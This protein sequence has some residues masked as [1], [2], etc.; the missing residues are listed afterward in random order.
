MH[1]KKGQ[2]TATTAAQA[3]KK[4]NQ[5]NNQPVQATQ[6]HLK[7]LEKDEVTVHPAWQTWCHCSSSSKQ[8]H[9]HKRKCNGIPKQSVKMHWIKDQLTAAA[10]A[11]ANK[12]KKTKTTINLCGLAA[13]P[14]NVKASKGTGKKTRSLCIQ[15]G[16]L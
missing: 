14:S 4:Q 5:N 11:Q 12:N 2:L 16:N 3:N 9:T 6:K 13:P 7:A 10:V 8:S 1:Q 15:S